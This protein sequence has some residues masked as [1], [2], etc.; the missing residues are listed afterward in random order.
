MKAKTNKNSVSL[1][2]NYCRK[3]S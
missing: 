1:T 3:N 2:F